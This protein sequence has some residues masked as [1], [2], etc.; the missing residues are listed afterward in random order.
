[1]QAGGAGGLKRLSRTDSHEYLSVENSGRVNQHNILMGKGRRW[2]G[3]TENLRR[4]TTGMSPANSCENLLN[5]SRTVST[6]RPLGQQHRPV[7]GGAG[8]AKKEGGQWMDD[9]G[10][11]AIGGAGPGARGGGGEGAATL[12]RNVS[13]ES[14]GAL[15][16]NMSGERGRERERA[17][18]GGLL[19]I[20]Q[21]RACQERLAIPKP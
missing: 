15:Q 18:V 3:S 17:D 21:A 12:C 10:A 2:G 19:P 20:C 8:M 6:N 14:I 5:M 11:G 1:M 13:T 7:G 4:L 9:S 16:R